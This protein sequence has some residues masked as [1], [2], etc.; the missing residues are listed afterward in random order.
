MGWCALPFSNPA[1]VPSFRDFHQGKNMISRC[2]DFG[3]Q[4]FFTGP[5]VASSQSAEN[6]QISPNK[7]NI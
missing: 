3:V 7:G 4:D 1:M 6:I 5:V 2:R